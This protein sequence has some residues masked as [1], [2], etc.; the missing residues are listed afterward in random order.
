M[1]WSGWYRFLLIGCLLLTASPALAQSALEVLRDR[2]DLARV[3]PGAERLAA[4]EGKPPAAAAYA[5]DTRLG[6]VLVTGDVVDAAGYSGKPI[7]VAVGVTEAG[8]IV[9]G[10]LLKHAEPIVLVGIPESR[11][12]EFIAGYVGYN[13]LTAT[14]GN[15]P[16]VDIV[17]GA[18]VTVIVIGD[19]MVRAA[20]Q[21]LRSR[22]GAA[23][24]E[25]AAARRGLDL[26]QN[27][28]RSWLD[29]LG[30]GSVRRLHLDFQTVNDA[31]ARLDPRAA[32][33]PERGDPGETFIDLYAAPLAA[34]TIARAL[35]GGAA[36]PAILVMASGR[37]SFRG[38]GFVR[39]GL[40]DRIELV[41]GE[42][43][44]RFRDR[45]YERLGDVAAEGAPHFT[46]IGLFT[47]PEGTSFDPARPWRLRLLVNRAVGALEK[48]FLTWD[49]SYDLPER[50]LQPAAAAAPAAVEEAG[51]PL[52]LRIWR[53][54]D[55]DIGILCA[56]LGL[57]TGIFFFQD[58][59]TQR[60]RLTGWLRLGFL[61]WTLLWL[62]WWANA[63]L[64][65]VNI[66][67]LTN[68]LV[69]G[70]RWDS[71]LI[72]PLLFILWSAVAA[73]L[74]F[75]GRGA[76]CGW[77]CPFGALQEFV[78]RLARWLKVPQVKLPWGLHERLWPIKYMVFL[79][80]FGFSLY[81]LAGAEQAAE[82]EPFKTA[83][84][85]KFVRDWPFVLYAGLLLLAAAFV[86]RFFCRY[87]CPLGAAL[88]IPA[89][90][91]MFDWLKRHRECGSPCQRC[92]IE[93]P[94][95][96]IHP[97]GRINPNECISCLHCQTL[98]WDQYRCPAMVQ[99][100]LRRERGQAMSA[101]PKAPA[102]TTP[103][104]GGT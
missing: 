50:Y 78:N 38:S 4:V 27:E 37:Y 80:L 35:L 94:V 54:R 34:P 96:A 77:L 7:Q 42:T 48:V 88:A 91:R 97:D 72:D 75:W 12:A 90:L 59:L 63:Q 46:E 22:T 15:R 33:R 95:E 66:L 51:E 58:W 11:I 23:P 19:T 103:Q 68:A 14:V 100:R 16:P 99:R 29:L 60:P 28:Q 65:V 47:L 71:F 13:V 98:Y 70:F 30:D 82:V 36:R 79:G 26:A 21:V 57:L 32:Q 61:A 87:L 104:S 1:F 56:G 101:P 10:Q 31:F 52:W 53:G 84:I 76:F 62:G 49:L 17:S 92:A 5:G 83:I 9:G 40:F 81:S 69:T 25:S 20:Q 64:S 85:L 43:T 44:I 18:T 89:R 67:A 55:L 45:N 102:T 24:A 39:G 41:Q 6:Y 93:C 74:L 86:D 8:E 73:A 2:I 3:F